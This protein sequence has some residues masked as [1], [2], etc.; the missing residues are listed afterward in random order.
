MSDWDTFGDVNMLAYGGGFIRHVA[1]RRFHVIEVTNMDEAC[2]RD[3]EGQ[4]RY[5]IELK[6]INL[7]EADVDGAL[8]SCGWKLED[9]IVINEHDGSEVAS[10]EHTD[11]VIAESML[12]YG[13]SAPL[14]SWST[15]NPC[16]KLVQ[17][18]ALS[19]KLEK[20]SEAWE[21]RM[22]RP[23]NKLGSTAR[24]YAR[25]DF[26]SA[27]ARG[28]L[29]GDKS[30]ALMA[31]ISGKILAPPAPSDDP[32]AFLA[33]YMDGKSGGEKADPGDD[34][35]APEYIRGFEVGQRVAAGT[36]MAPEWIK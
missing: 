31:K 16:A 30:S 6:E 32:L 13:G 36:Q 27:L 26:D 11:R 21:E 35:L 2:G 4:P 3:N 34:D 9:G 20:D 33:G 14:E 19:R 28:L 17:A 22:N 24:E 25:G 7:D 5:V 12:G 18:R 23:V 10:R 8:R 15:N 1:A 29:S